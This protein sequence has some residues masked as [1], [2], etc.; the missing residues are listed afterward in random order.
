MS[1][2]IIKP[3]KQGQ[4]DGACGFYAILN[5]MTALE[6]PL[7]RKEVFTQ[8]IAA[9]MQDVNFSSYFDGTRRGT[10]KIRLAVSLIT[11][12]LSSNFLM[13]KL[14]NVINLHCQFPTG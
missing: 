12:I 7:Q 9:F 1:S 13:I 3:A 11:L 2:R 5:A 4:L 8:V 6:H 14:K 10:I